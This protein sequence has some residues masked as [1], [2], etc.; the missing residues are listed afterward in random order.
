ML[1]S[2]FS[3][4]VAR[5]IGILAGVAFSIGE[6]YLFDVLRRHGIFRIYSH[7]TAWLIGSFVAPWVAYHLVWAWC[8]SL[9]PC[10]SGCGRMV[11]RNAG[12]CLGCGAPIAKCK[13]IVGTAIPDEARR[14][15]AHRPPLYRPR[16]ISQTEK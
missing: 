14:D 2:R 5:V 12:H 1:R 15:S 4:G 3:H 7:S 9:G 8:S 13:L 16:R 6:A 11:S 10:P